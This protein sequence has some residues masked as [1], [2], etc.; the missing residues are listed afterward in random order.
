MRA[1]HLSVTIVREDDAEIRRAADACG[2]RAVVLC[3]E[4]HQQRDEVR[5]DQRDS[6]RV[7]P[8]DHT[9]QST[10]RQYVLTV[11]FE[12]NSG[13]RWSAVGGGASIG[14][15]IAFARE[16]AP[17]DRYWRAIKLTDVYGD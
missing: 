11:E 1:R 9:L 17:D 10:S 16:S 4:E 13:E 6:F 8:S 14:D 7:R 2:P 15:A 5:H 3:T 12:S